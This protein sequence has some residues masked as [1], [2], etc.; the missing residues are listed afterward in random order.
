[1]ERLANKLSDA[2]QRQLLDPDY[3]EF[4]CTQEIVFL[5]IDSQHTLVPLEVTH[6][7]VQLIRQLHALNEE[8]QTTVV[9]G[10]GCPR[11]LVS[12]EGPAHLLESVLPGTTVPD[13]LGI[14]RST[15]YRRMDDYNISIRG[16]YSQCTYEEL[17]DLVFQIKQKMP[18]AGYRLVKGN[19]RHKD[20][21]CSG[22]EWDHPCIRSTALGYSQGWIS[23]DV[24]WG[25][26]FQC[27]VQTIWCILT[28][29]I[30]SLGKL[31]YW[32]W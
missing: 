8:R 19:W 29:T 14:S 24:L 21:D 9:Q 5:D 13:L 12:N 31:H 6:K 22:I 23:S 2:L 27:L 17:D 28:L 16:F 10:R 3:L 20:I 30:S 4:V 32:S 1:M 15:L 25:E 7:L 26:H 11:I 18:H